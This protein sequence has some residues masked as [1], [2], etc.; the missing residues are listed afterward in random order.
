[1]S[2]LS[3]QSQWFQCGSHASCVQCLCNA[4]AQQYL[5]VGVRRLSVRPSVLVMSLD[6]SIFC[7]T[8]KL[9]SGVR[10]FDISII[11]LEKSTQFEHRQAKSS[12]STTE[13]LRQMSL[14]ECLNVQILYDV[15]WCQL[16]YDLSAR[17]LVRP[18]IHLSD[19]LDRLLFIYSECRLFWVCKQ[20]IL[21]IV[22]HRRSAVSDLR[23][24]QD[25]SILDSFI[26]EK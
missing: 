25:W 1:M 3:T 22:D 24:N 7:C 21:I 17:L 12:T 6:L 2:S 15:T 19:R 18:S 8:R 10:V 23:Y 9:Y 26:L 11:T 4:S 5:S 20:N 13:H 14:V 16:K